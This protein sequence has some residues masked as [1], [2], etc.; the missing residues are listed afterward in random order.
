MMDENLYYAN[1]TQLKQKAYSH[2]YNYT[3]SDLMKYLSVAENMYC[4][5]DNYKNYHESELELYRSKYSANNSNINFEILDEYG[6]VILKN[7]NKIKAQSFSFSSS[8]TSEIMYFGNEWYKVAYDNL[9]S[10]YKTYNDVLPSA[11]ETESEPVTHFYDT[12]EPDTTVEASESEPTTFTPEFTEES[13]SLQNAEASQ[14]NIPSEATPTLKK[15]V[16]NVINNNSGNSTKLTYYYDDIIDEKIYFYCKDEVSVFPYDITEICFYQSEYYVNEGNEVLRLY[17]PHEP[18]L[19]EKSFKTKL[20]ID[21]KEINVNYSYNGS[22]YSSEFISRLSYLSLITKDMTESDLTFTYKQKGR[23][24]LQVNA[25]IPYSCYNDDLY[26]FTGNILDVAVNYKDN[27]IPIT[28]TFAVLVLIILIY[29]FWSAGYITGHD[30]PVARGLHA[31]P[32]DVYVLLCIICDLCCMGLISFGDDL[33]ITA[34]VL[35]LGLITV[36]FIYTIP[37]RIRAKSL[38]SNNLTLKLYHFLKDIRDAL[39][40]SNNK[41][42]IVFISISAF[43]LLSVCEILTYLILDLDEFAICLL[44]IIF[45]VIATPLLAILIISLMTL[46]NG[47]RAIS[48]GDISYRINTSFL[49]GP[50]KI[51]A[52]Y[53]NSI[54][55][56]INNA[57]DER[58]RSESLKTELITNVSHDLKTPLTSIVNY[59]DLL[60]KEPIDN[61]DA[62]Q[63]IEVIDRQSQRLK[64]LTVDIV[65]A[66]KA[67]T[68]NIE[69]RKE[70][71]V[72]NVILLQTSGEYIERLEEK[73]LIL[74]TEFPKNEIIVLTDGRLLWRVIDNLMNNIC[75]YSLP[76]TRV[77]LSLWEDNNN[78]YISFR[79]IS[80]EKLNINPENLT[81]RFVRGDTS[82]NTEGSGLGLSIANSL[83]ELMGGNLSILIDGDLFK[84][85]LSFPKII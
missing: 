19:S 48:K 85:T 51:H 7:D 11:F 26:K 20:I 41:K 2:L 45:R 3:A 70:N 52:Q 43:L 68:G 84:V 10:E 38:M 28:I 42:L 65:E 9:A 25:D 15:E 1:A 74:E 46:N 35:G 56:I 39:Y 33:S 64:K 18:E 29:L 13:T 8:F 27:I 40:E 69:V 17:S 49:K 5:N 78:A 77:Y 76:G 50:L 16:I 31:I 36:S 24:H 53:L 14:E 44:I 62:L 66:S 12:T 72:L 59:V 57:V 47:A 22:F 58:V 32:S 30:K 23:L 37:V 75:K 83:T 4:N 82:R 73:K 81:E 79:N 60:K 67:A 71:A 55:D 80:R 21:G 61:P 54:N 63:Y 34:G 6:N